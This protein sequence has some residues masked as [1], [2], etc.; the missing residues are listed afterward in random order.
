MPKL[1][2]VLK[3]YKFSISWGGALAHRE[4]LEFSL[5]YMQKIVA[6]LKREH[7]GRKVPVILFTKGGG[8]WLE[9]MIATGAD[10]FGFR[11]DYANKRGSSNS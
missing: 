5:K 8:Q 4:Y 1:R 3:P 7:E 11:L 9:P 6:G 10:G 2:R